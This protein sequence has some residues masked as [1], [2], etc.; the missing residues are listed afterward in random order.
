MFNKLKVV[1]GGG[2]NPN[3]SNVSRVITLKMEVGVLALVCSLPTVRSIV[4]DKIKKCGHREKTLVEWTLLFT[5]Q[6]L[7]IFY[8]AEISQKIF[9]FFLTFF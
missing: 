4:H 9:L 5:P 2:I 8:L 3:L 7:W 6:F 1:Q